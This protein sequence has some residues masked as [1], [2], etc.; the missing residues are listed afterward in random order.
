MARSFAVSA[1]SM[2][3]VCAAFRVAN[4]SCNVF[5]S[6]DNAFSFSSVNMSECTSAFDQ[7]MNV[8]VNLSVCAKA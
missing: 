8:S 7:C 5:F 3:S 2:A 4:F 6:S 1:S